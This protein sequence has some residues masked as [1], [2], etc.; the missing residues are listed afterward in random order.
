MSIYPFRGGGRAFVLFP[1]WNDWHTIYYTKRV[2]SVERLSVH[3]MFNIYMLFVK[4]DSLNI[5]STSIHTHIHTD[6]APKC[7]VVLFMCKI[8]KSKKTDRGR[9]RETTRGQEAMS[10]GWIKY[11]VQ[12][13]AHTYCIN[14]R[15]RPLRPL[16]LQKIS[17]CPLTVVKD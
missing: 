1:A 8:N 12:H 16:K 3:W 11:V 5:K 4:H 17:C 7:A 15:K 13:M 2:C 14:V 10:D 6:K 9:E